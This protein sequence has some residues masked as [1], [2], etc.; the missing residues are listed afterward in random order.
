MQLCPGTR[1]VLLSLH[2]S[3]KKKADGPG[4]VAH[5]RLEKTKTSEKRIRGNRIHQQGHFLHWAS[6]RGRDP[7]RPG[8][9]IIYLR[10][11]KG[12]PWIGIGGS[13]CPHNKTVLFGRAHTF[14]QWWSIGYLRER[15]KYHHPSKENIKVVKKGP[16]R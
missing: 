16:T 14:L 5:R 11:K 8:G 12:T 2:K 6:R 10:R 1:W 7:S 3:K 15:E 13:R 9:R 4:S